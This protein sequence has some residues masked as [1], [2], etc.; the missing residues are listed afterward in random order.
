MPM[1]S[2]SLIVSFLLMI[3]F[4]RVIDCRVRLHSRHRYTKLYFDWRRASIPRTGY[5]QCSASMKRLTGILFAV[6]PPAHSYKAQAQ[7]FSGAFVYHASLRRH[8]TAQYRR[9]E[10]LYIASLFHLYLRVFGKYSRDDLRARYYLPLI[11]ASS[12]PAF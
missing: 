6:P 7:V 10:I 3:D 2:L 11:A 8:C 4:A 1:I 12:L 5:I 9:F